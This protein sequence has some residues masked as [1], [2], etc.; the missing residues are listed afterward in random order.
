MVLAFQKT[1]SLQLI[2]KARLLQYEQNSLGSSRIRCSK[3]SDSHVA[4][5]SSHSRLSGGWY[6][7]SHTLG[8]LTA[9]LIVD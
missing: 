3:N 8:I 9:Y 2:L 4:T 6:K 5:N 1:H 7:A